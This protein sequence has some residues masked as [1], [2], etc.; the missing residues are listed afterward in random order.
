[1]SPTTLPDRDSRSPHGGRVQYLSVLSRHD[2]CYDC[3][4]EGEHGRIRVGPCDLTPPMTDSNRYS[5]RAVHY[6]GR[7]LLPGCDNVLPDHIRPTI[8]RGGLLS[9]V[10]PVHPRLRDIFGRKALMMSALFIFAVGDLLCGFAKTPV[11]LYVFRAI[12]G[13]G[14]GG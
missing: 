14:G 5:C 11:Q 1:M 3:T 2:V 6:L 13:I 8:V 4:S 9:V 12:A 10:R 7:N